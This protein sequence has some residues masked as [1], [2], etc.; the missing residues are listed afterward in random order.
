MFV[1]IAWFQDIVVGEDIQILDV[2]CVWKVDVASSNLGY[3]RLYWRSG[4]T[5]VTE[6]RSI[7]TW[8]ESEGVMDQTSEYIFQDL[9]NR[10][11]ATGEY[12][13]RYDILCLS[14]K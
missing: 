7:A 10:M 2:V 13:E 11:T 6:L 4:P 8:S 5:S 12:S 9:R 14:K 1:Q 3:G